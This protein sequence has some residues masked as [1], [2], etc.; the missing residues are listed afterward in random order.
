[1]A[2]AAL[3][4]AA[5][6]IP[7]QASAAALPTDPAI[8]N[9]A[10]ADVSPLGVTDGDVTNQLPSSY[11]VKIADLGGGST[12]CPTWTAAGASTTYACTTWW[13]PSG[14]SDDQIR[15][16]NFDTDGFMVESAYTVKEN[17]TGGRTYSVPAF[18]WVKFSSGLNVNCSV[19]SGKVLCT[20]G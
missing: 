9:G 6:A 18:K 8:P 20:I 5:L 1:M 19:S 2:F 14:Q 13:L 11:T 16:A 10:G 17:R 3:A 15:G 12:S 4:A 7:G